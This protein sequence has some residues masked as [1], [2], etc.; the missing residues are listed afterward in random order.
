MACDY[1]KKGE[2]GEKSGHNWELFNQKLNE[3]G[4]NITYQRD[5]T[6]HILPTIAY[7][8]MWATQIGMPEKDFILGKLQVK[9]PGI[10]YTIEEALPRIQQKIDKN[11]D[12]INPEIFSANKQYVLMVIERV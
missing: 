5:I 10:H 3:Q 9:A 7:V 2:A 6:A 8:Y 4:F 1:F 11:I 12:T